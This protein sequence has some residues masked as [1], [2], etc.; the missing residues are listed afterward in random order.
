MRFAFVTITYPT[1]HAR[2]GAGLDTQQLARG[3][4][5]RGHTAHVVCVSADGYVAHENDE[6]VSVSFVPPRKIPVRPALKILAVL[7]GLRDLK[8]AWCGWGMIETAYAA[9]HEVKQL[10]RQQPFDVVQVI[11]T[12]GLALFCVRSRKHD[13]PIV[14]RGHGFVDPALPGSQW[15][16]AIFQQRLERAALRRADFVAANSGYLRDIYCAQYGVSPDRAGVLYNGFELPTRSDT[17]W[18]IRRLNGWGADDPIVL[19]IGRLEFMKGCDVLFAAVQQAQ[20]V[21]SNLRLVLLGETQPAFQDEYA[22]FMRAHVA[23]VW[24]PGNVSPV[25]VSRALREATVLAHPSRKETFGRTL[26]EAQLHGV[27]VIGTKVGGVPEIVIDGETGLLVAAGQDQPLAQ[28]LLR[29]VQDREFAIQM[30]QRARARA[31]QLFGL[32]GVIDRQIALAQ[33]LKSS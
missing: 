7:P 2:E 13:V 31:E 24:H 21:Q 5:Q 6:G 28:A 23:G 11:D 17:R 19:Y 12:G 29:L 18:D 1:H 16:G 27:P 14:I 4:V 3:V 22:A 20:Q 32:P 33:A 8:E 10:H 25:Q 15:C 30:G 9:W 26:V